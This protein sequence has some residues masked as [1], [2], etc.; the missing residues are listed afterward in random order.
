M[1][2][3]IPR[4]VGTDLINLNVCAQS[5][6]E[7]LASLSDYLLKKDYVLESF[8]EAIIL[9]EKEYPTGLQLENIAVA[10]PHTY[11]QHVKKPFI[12]INR[13]AKPVSFIQMGTDDEKLD[14]K[15]VMV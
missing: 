12:F 13:L 7:L 15:Y 3:I 8:E 9:R 11:A 1:S 5:Q 4:L 14:V 10:I 6:S 2:P